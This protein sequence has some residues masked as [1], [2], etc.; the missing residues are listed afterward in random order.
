MP[1]IIDAVLTLHLLARTAR[2]GGQQQQQQRRGRRLLTCARRDRSNHLF[3]LNANNG[4][5]VVQGL[6]MLM[7]FGRLAARLLTRTPPYHS[8]HASI[9][10][11]N[12]SK[13]YHSGN[14]WHNQSR[15]MVYRRRH[16]LFRTGFCQCSVYQK[17]ARR[18]EQ[19]QC[20]VVEKP[21]PWRRG[22]KKEKRQRA[23]KSAGG[24]K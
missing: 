24:R 13:A 22:R 12:Q 9:W 20:R 23:S 6:Q 11:R 21:C 8:P 17:S 5:V 15:E 1:G 14:P 19:G 18:T 10:K 4:R 16:H 2:P 3:A 7:I